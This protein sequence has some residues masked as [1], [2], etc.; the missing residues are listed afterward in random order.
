MKIHTANYPR[1]LNAIQRRKRIGQVFLTLLSSLW[2]A[3]V[4]H[5]QETAAT[6]HSSIADKAAIAA[7]IENYSKAVDNHDETLFMSGMLD[8]QIPVF[9]AN[10]TPSQKTSLQSKDMHN[11]SDLRGAFFHSKTRYRISFD[12][13]SIQQDHSLAA[14]FVHFV[15]QPLP[16]GPAVDG[17]KTL[18]LMKVGNQWKIVSE[19]FTVG[20]LNPKT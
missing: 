1:G 8:D 7:V 16:N 12:H 4:L 18:Q 3:T 20:Y 10:D 14:V 19:L 11:L 2:V 6:S 17:W 5:S 15:T 13:M 9:S